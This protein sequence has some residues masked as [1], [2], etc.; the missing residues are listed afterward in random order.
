MRSALKMEVASFFEVSVNYQ[1]IQRPILEVYRCMLLAF[2][3][4]L[5][6]IQIIGCLSSLF[7]KIS[8]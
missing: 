7:H 1:T 6:V 2:I 4:D 3:I 5:I 8:R